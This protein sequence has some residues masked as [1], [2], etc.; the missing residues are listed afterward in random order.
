[1]A[2][3]GSNFNRPVNYTPPQ[4][5]ND[6][7]NK[8]PEG[9]YKAV[10]IKWA[11]VDSD[12][13]PALKAQ[14]NGVMSARMYFIV[15]D[16]E[17]EKGPYY[18]ADMA[19]LN[20]LVKAFDNEAELL[21]VPDKNDS[22]KVRDFLVYCADKINNSGN[23]V[24]FEVNSEGWCN[25]KEAYIHADCNFLLRV[26]EIN[27][28]NENKVPGWFTIDF[29]EGRHAKKIKC[30]VEILGSPLGAITPWNTATFDTTIPY[31]FKY[32]D[33][34][35]DFERKEDGNMTGNGTQ[36]FKFS[37]VYAPKIYSDDRT[38]PP[39]E[40]DNLVPWLIENASPV[41]FMAKVK[42]SRAKKS[43]IMYYNVDWYNVE[44][45]PEPQ[46]AN[47]NVEP[48]KAQELDIPEEMKPKPKQEETI[49]DNSDID[50]KAQKYLHEALNILADGEIFEQDYSLTSPGEKVA[51]QYL[52]PLKESGVFP[53]QRKIKE[54][55]Y[56]EGSVILTSL[57]E[58]VEDGEKK[59]KLA[60]KLDKLHEALLGFDEKE[61]EQAFVFG[62]EDVF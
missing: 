43:G 27:S 54:V 38:E 2:K 7:D 41:V 19:N 28:K 35:L 52:K 46:L 18:M 50:G 5:T 10:G 36:L 1:M 61:P 6:N 21:P 12:N 22:E 48:I 33:G 55:T 53:K 32:Y 3:F 39:A 11:F 17:Q 60:H 30:R 34:E 4:T 9:E 25:V 23:E 59:V 15:K 49:E 14:S 62:P 16:K 47:L 58:T 45:V 42:N 13:Q 8:Y 29:G 51:M 57:V 26:T 44:V 40:S 37:H 24:D 31:S 20:A 56:D